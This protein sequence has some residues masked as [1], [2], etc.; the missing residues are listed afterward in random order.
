MRYGKRGVPY[1]HDYVHSKPENI[2]AR[3]LVEVTFHTMYRIIRNV[4]FGVRG[5]TL[6][7]YEGAVEDAMC[8]TLREGNP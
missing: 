5:I 3:F 6:E 8:G 4:Q 7:K 2:S 1:C